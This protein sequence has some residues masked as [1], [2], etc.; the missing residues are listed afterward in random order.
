MR[1]DGNATSMILGV[2]QATRTGEVDKSRPVR[3]AQGVSSAFN[4]QLSDLLAKIDDVQPSSGD[5]RME[6]V[7]AIKAQLAQGTYNISGAAVAE[8]MLK[9]LKE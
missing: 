4:V 6:K 8:K 1:I 7:N 2:Q 9:L 5:I 3:A